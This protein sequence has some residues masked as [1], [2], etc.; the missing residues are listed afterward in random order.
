V[1][2]APDLDRTVSATSTDAFGAAAMTPPADG[3]ALAAALVHEFQHAKLGALLDLVDLWEQETDARYY[4]PWRD[5]A[6]PLG[7]LVHGTY[8]YLGVTDFWRIQRLAADRDGDVGRANIAHFEFARWREQAWRTSRF[9]AEVGAARLTAAGRRFVHGMRGTLEQWRQLPVPA[10]LQD[11]ARDDALAHRTTWR[12]RN[13]Q[14]ELEIL[15]RLTA[16]WIAGRPCPT[17]RRPS[18]TVAQGVARAEHD[19][20]RDGRPHLARMRLTGSRNHDTPADVV[21][22]DRDDV[23][24]GIVDADV[25]YARGD[26]AAAARSYLR[27]VAADP[28]HRWPWSGLTLAVRRT[29]PHPLA[30]ALLCYPELIY[31][32][33]CEVSRRVG[34]PPDP[35]AVAQWLSP[36][37][38]AHPP[39]AGRG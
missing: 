3:W 5:D 20:Q 32:L 30:H 19:S 28:Y 9:V 22:L 31:R 26:P 17:G 36:L 7:R 15:D 38:P 13:L 34:A 4:A 1:P 27:H 25:Y 12:L 33:T 23:V 29:G 10:E 18:T 11:L 14:P 6:R 35:V 21:R 39:G 24:N 37:R 16:A 2:L 8:A